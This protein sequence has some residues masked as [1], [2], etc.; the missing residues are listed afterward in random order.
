MA[1]MKFILIARTV[2]FS[3]H[4]LSITSSADRGRR[5]R[6][7][8]KGGWRN[9]VLGFRIRPQT[10][11]NRPFELKK[12][13]K[14]VLTRAAFERIPTAFLRLSLNQKNRRLRSDF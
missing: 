9:H 3:A 2:P 8:S 14:R 13:Q 1:D 5:K 12:S 11:P 4:G 6:R 7:I 10:H